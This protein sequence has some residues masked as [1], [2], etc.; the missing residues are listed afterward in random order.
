VAV[1]ANYVSG[2]STVLVTLQTGPVT[3]Q[4]ALKVNGYL[5]VYENIEVD[6][7]AGQT[8][9]VNASGRTIFGDPLVAKQS[10]YTCPT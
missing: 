6:C 5:N 4:H 8:L 2:G 3:T 7:P 9:K 1:N 10:T